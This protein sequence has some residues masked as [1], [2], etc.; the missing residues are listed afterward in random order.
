M[1]TLVL[2]IN[3]IKEVITKNNDVMAFMQ[4]SDEYSKVELTLFPDTYKKYNNL[5][6]KN[7]IKVNGRVEKRYDKYQII[8][9]T[10]EKLNWYFCSFMIQ[11]RH[12]VIICEK[13][14]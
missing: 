10:I 13:N 5:S 9:N 8:V 6:V 11:Y 3:N 2:E 7:I 1:I 12:E 4:A 14:W